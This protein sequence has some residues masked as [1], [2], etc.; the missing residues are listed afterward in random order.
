MLDAILCIGGWVLFGG[1]LALWVLWTDL[2]R[3]LFVN[4]RV[5]WKHLE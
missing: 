5:K 1:V 3:E 4:G 2:E